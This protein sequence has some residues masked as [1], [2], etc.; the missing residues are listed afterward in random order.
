MALDSLFTWLNER[1]EP[2]RFAVARRSGVSSSYG[3]LSNR[4]PQK[5]EPDIALI[6]VQGMGEPG[7]ARFQFQSHA[8]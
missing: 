5:A 8:L 4:E 2:K 3:L 7:F 6:L 1:L